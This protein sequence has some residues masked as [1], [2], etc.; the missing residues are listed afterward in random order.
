MNLDYLGAT[1]I[2]WRTLYT[3]KNP[4]PFWYYLPHKRI[5]G[6]MKVPR[7]HSIRA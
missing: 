1:V 3:F 6:K 5:K 2:D 7:Y 4:N